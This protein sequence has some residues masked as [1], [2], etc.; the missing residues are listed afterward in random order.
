MTLNRGTRLGPYEIIEPL[1]AGGMGQVYRATDT[2]LQRQVA[3]K[4]VAERWH[5]QPELH[6]RFLVEA[7]AIAALSHPHICQIYDVGSHD[8]AH[9]I[10]MEILE[11]ETLA[12]RLARG[13]L[14][15]GQALAVASEVAG[16]LGAAHA[17]GIVHRD[18][19]PSNVILGRNGAKLLDFGL[20]QLSRPSAFDDKGSTVVASDLTAPGSPVGT[21]HYMSPEQIRGEVTDSR[22]DVFALGALMYEMVVGR[23]AF[24]GATHQDL[25]SAILTADPPALETVLPDVPAS[26]ASG[27]RICLNKSPEDRWHSAADVR[28]ALAAARHD[29]RRTSVAPPRRALAWAGAVIVAA[30]AGITGLSLSRPGPRSEALLVR[31]TLELGQFAVTANQNSIVFAPDGKSIIYAGHPASSTAAYTQKG[32]LYQ[33]SLVTGVSEPI[34]G[35]EGLAEGAGGS[36]ARMPFVSPD[37]QWL[38]FENGKQFMKLPIGGGRPAPITPSSYGS[39]DWGDDNYIVF[40]GPNGTGLR[41]VSANGGE[42]TVL[43]TRTPE[44]DGRDHRYPVVLPGSQAVLFGVGTGSSDSAKIVVEDLRTRVRKDLVVGTW[45]FRYSPTGHLVYSRGGAIFAQAFDVA[46]LAVTGAP[47]KIAEGVV[48]RP[49]A[50]F[51][52]SASGALAFAPASPNAQSGELVMVTLGGTVTATGQ[53]GSFDKP[54]FSRDGRRLAVIRGGNEP[55]AWIYDL[56]RT[57]FHQ[58]TFGR[59]MDAIWSADGGLTLSEGRPRKSRLVAR[60]GAENAAETAITPYIDAAERPIGWADGGRRL[61]FERHSQNEHDIWAVETGHP[62]EP[63]VVTPFL[64]NRTSV[65]PDG[66]WLSYTSVETSKTAQ[67]YL[68][69]L[70]VAA[71]RVQASVRNGAE[72]TW[73]PDSRRLYF[74]SRASDG[75][76]NAVWSVDVGQG[77]N[78]EIGAP[79]ERFKAPNMI[80]SFSMSPDGKTF[81]MIRRVG[82]PIQTI[83]LIQNWLRLFDTP[84]R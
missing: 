57:T 50:E 62:P 2:R 18:L 20:A 3:I 39:A 16:A 56:V 10:V 9:F 34:E 60:P 65:S 81:A 80:G 19:K 61:L 28:R 79:V 31:S 5:G 74:Y 14:P 22:S 48:D 69:R 11:G 75:D 70:D 1:G 77:A 82:E 43:T 51:A 71:P 67:V 83:R 49:S 44:D 41:R 84:A 72:G 42:V 55:N 7:K 29:D 38:G 52:V 37:G 45:T 17:A 25:V 23:R 12:A 36:V 8:G 27:V 68:Q 13:P 46:Q 53:T 24:D 76:E 33:H 30:V 78:P 73:S 63:V 32:Q 35:T 66:R 4:M 47:I 40:A 21:W 59:Y 54:R 15:I 26:Y 58:V 6:S 64:K